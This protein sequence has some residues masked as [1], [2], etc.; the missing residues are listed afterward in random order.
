MDIIKKR[1]SPVFAMLCIFMLLFV[2]CSTDKRKEGNNI[3]NYDEKIQVF[4][5]DASSGKLEKTEIFLSEDEAENLVNSLAT[6]NNKLSDDTLKKEFLLWYTV[7]LNDDTTLQIDAELNYSDSSDL[8]Y[9]YV[10]QHNTEPATLY[11]T[12]IDSSIIE[13]LKK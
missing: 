5:E 2:G 3:F 9:M 7:K 4:F 1:I 8:T 12:F 13:Q 10:I 11:G 6:Y